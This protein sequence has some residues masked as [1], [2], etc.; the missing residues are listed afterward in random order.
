MCAIRAA[1]TTIQGL[2]HFHGV[3]GDGNGDTKT[4]RSEQ[5]ALAGNLNFVWL[6]SELLAFPA[7]LRDTDVVMDA[8]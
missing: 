5:I 2:K 4:I 8:N 1:Y 3:Y 7:D 6:D